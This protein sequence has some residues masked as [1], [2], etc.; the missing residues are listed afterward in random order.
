MGWTKHKLDLKPI[1]TLAKK[2]GGHDEEQDDR[3]ELTI[4]DR[5]THRRLH[6]LPVPYDFPKGIFTPEELEKAESNALWEALKIA[7][8]NRRIAEQEFD[9]LFRLYYNVIR[10]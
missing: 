7:D 9:V 10:Q 4:V 1:L 5:S 8:I 6:Y 3:L 2:L